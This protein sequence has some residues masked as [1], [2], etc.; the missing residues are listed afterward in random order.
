MRNKRPV[1]RRPT[2]ND[3]EA[4]EGWELHIWVLGNGQER[5][6]LR[7]R[8]LDRKTGMYTTLQQYELPGME[9]AKKANP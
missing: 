5:R 9:M 2:E 4:P 1:E 7:K 6:E 8:L 3:A